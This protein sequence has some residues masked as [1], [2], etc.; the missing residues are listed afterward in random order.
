M[1]ERNK[2]RI[3]AA[4]T[5]G[6]HDSGAQNLVRVALSKYNA[7]TEYPLEPLRV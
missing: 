3:K 6:F 1:L 2:R 5:I 7:V 4:A